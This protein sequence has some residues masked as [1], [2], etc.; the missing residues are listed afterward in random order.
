MY[1]KH[2]YILIFCLAATAIG[3]PSAAWSAAEIN[4]KA[5]AVEFNEDD[6]STREAGGL[7][8]RGGLKIESEHSRFGGL[9]ALAI[10]EDRS[11]FIA[12]SDRGAQIKGS[13]L[14]GENGDLKN[15]QDLTFFEL[16]GLGGRGFPT[17]YDGD[18]E[19]IARRPGGDMVISFERNH[20]LLTYS[21]ELVV[22]LMRPPGID[23]APKNGGIEALTDLPGGGLLAIT[24]NLETDTGTRGWL[25]RQDQWSK[26]SLQKEPDFHPTGAA[27]APNGDVY[28]LFRKF[29]F[30]FGSSVRIIKI[31]AQSIKPNAHLTG[32]TVFEI[33]SPF[34]LD[35][36]E[37]I[38][39]RQGSDGKNYLYLVSDDN[40]SPLQNT[41]LM[42][43]EIKR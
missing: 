31:A 17:A 42:M 28:I 26:I 10:S 21:G 23:D 7:I 18:S 39:I 29:S 30:F 12:I 24:E 6:P 2:F 20:R 33:A 4:F 38:D 9:S 8:Y 40:F 5:V 22:E 43:F 3:L 15:L 19:S 41:Y 14:Y 36:Y 25:W 11:R 34:T 32:Q 37:G 16:H 35:N 1:F 27:T 13:L